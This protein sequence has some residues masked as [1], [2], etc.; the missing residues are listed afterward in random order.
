MREVGV[1]SVTS[2]CSPPLL[3]DSTQRGGDGREDGTIEE[4]RRWSRRQDD[5]QTLTGVPSRGSEVRMFRNSNARS[6]DGHGRADDRMKRDGSSRSE[7]QKEERTIEERHGGDG[8]RG[9]LRECLETATVH[10]KSLL[11]KEDY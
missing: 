3:S 6:S 2:S 10:L 7:D 8:D 9:R 1:S 5:R 4:A 11:Q